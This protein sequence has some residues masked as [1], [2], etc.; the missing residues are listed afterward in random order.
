MQPV[1]AAGSTQIA[2]GDPSSTENALLA[3]SEDKDVPLHSSSADAMDVQPPPGPFGRTT[4][5]S[6]DMACEGLV[7]L[8]GMIDFQPRAID[9]PEEANI[10]ALGAAISN[11]IAVSRTISPSLIALITVH[12]ITEVCSISARTL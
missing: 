3:R 10:F 2:H 5:L 9:A 12:F 7:C 11:G 4:G 1:Q 8:D 6:L